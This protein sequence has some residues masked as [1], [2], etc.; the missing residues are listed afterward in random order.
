M[1]PVALGALLVYLAFL[2]FYALWSVFLAYHLLK[3]APHQQT[4]VLSVGLFLGVTLVLLLV[5]IAAFLRLDWSAPAGLLV[6]T[7]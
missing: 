5:S 1:S 4:A 2:A 3:F 7:F 6:T